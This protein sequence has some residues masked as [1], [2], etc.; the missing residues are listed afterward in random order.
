M[1]STI[2]KPS[3]SVL[4]AGFPCHHALL[5]RA[6]KLIPSLKNYFYQTPD[7]KKGEE[8]KTRNNRFISESKHPLLTLKRL[9]GQFDPPLWFF[10]KCVF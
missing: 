2:V 9:G 1:I 10:Q 3:C 4:P 7:M 6:V 8:L 5:E